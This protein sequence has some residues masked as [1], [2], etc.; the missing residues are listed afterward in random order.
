MVETDQVHADLLSAA[1]GEIRFDCAIDSLA[2]AFSA[3]GGIIFELDR[4][5]GRIRDWVTDRLVIGGDGYDEQINAINPRMRYSLRHAPGHV[6]HDML[7]INEN[8]MKRHEFYDWLKRFSGFQYFIGS[9]LYDDGEI[10]VFHSIEF[11]ANHGPPDQSEIAA[12]ARTAR[13][14]AN[15]WR[16]RTRRAPNEDPASA[17]SWTPDYLPWAIF[18][19]DR[20]GALIEMNAAA[21]EMLAGAYCLF[22]DGEGLSTVHRPSQSAFR[23][24]IWL[25]LRGVAAECLVPARSPEPPLIAQIVPANCGHLRVPVPVAALLYVSNPM[26]GAR[27]VGPVLARLFGFTKAEQELSRQLCAG[28]DLT[29]AAARLAISRNTA[30][31]RLQSMYAKTGT[32]RQAEFLLRIGGVL[33]I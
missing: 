8:G 9:R 18:A 32:R 27:N 26:H 25:G 13:A 16:I 29:E 11:A 33:E 2:R 15:A 22:R 20:D 21:Q 17:R 7:F 5:S 12:F 19:L 24:A 1:A 30:R 10:S 6:A 4:E 3:G 23:D 31:N 14:V 28:R